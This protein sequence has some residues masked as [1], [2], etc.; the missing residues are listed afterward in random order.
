MDKGNKS[1]KSDNK[2]IICKATSIME[3]LQD[4]QNVVQ[5]LEVSL[6]SNND[7]ESIIRSVQIINRMVN[8][9]IEHECKELIQLCSDCENISQ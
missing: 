8:T 2:S 7:D 6:A 3:N 5:L 9:L 4:I 1:D